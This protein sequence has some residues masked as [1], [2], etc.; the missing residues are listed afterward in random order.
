MKTIADIR[1]FASEIE[2]ISGNSLPSN[3]NFQ[4]GKCLAMLHRIVMKLRERGFSLGDF[5]HL[6]VNFTTYSVA[7]GMAPSRRGKDYYHPWYRY[8]D[9]HVDEE[10]F[11]RLPLESDFGRVIETVK[12]LLASFFS[13]ETFGKNEIEAC[14]SE[15]LTQG[16]KMLMQFKEK[17]TAKRKAV[18]YLRY[19]DNARY[20]PLLRVTDAQNTLLLEA[21]LPEMIELNALGNIRVALN[22]ITIEP[23]KN[24]FTKDFTPIRFDY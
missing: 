9:V 23:R 16:E 21:D 18:V 3:L 14:F 2:N 17:T 13:T 22:H 1:I 19:L 4:S 15:A 8:Y 10:A 12:N 7:S 20:K 6:Y 11:R 5:D 24:V